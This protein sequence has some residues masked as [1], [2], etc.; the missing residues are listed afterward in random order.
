L[1]FK[2]NRAFAFFRFYS[3]LF[4]DFLNGLLLYTSFCTVALDG[5]FIHFFDVFGAK[6]FM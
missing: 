5:D 4:F 2:V 1:I 6:V 3:V